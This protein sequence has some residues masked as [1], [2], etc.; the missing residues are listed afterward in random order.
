MTTLLTA[1]GS[2]DFLAA[3]PVVLG[4]HPQQSL[5]MLT[6]GATR[7][8]HARVDLPP[9]GDD[10]E[11]DEI[12]ASLLTPSQRHGVGQVVFVVYS[13]DGTTAARLAARL[14]PAFAAGGIAV[15]DVLRAHQ[16]RWSRVPLRAGGR[17][18]V[19]VRY[20]DDHHPFRAQAVLDGRVTRG[21]R[22]AVRATVAR[23]VELQRRWARLV[24]PPD[25]AQVTESVVEADRDEPAALCALVAGWVE[26]RTAPDDAGAARVLRSARRVEVRDALLEAV[27]STAA[28]DHVQVWSQLLRGAPVECVPDTAAVT[29]FCAW[30]AGDGALAWCALDRC[31][32]VDPEHRLG[33]CLAQCLTRAIPPTVWHEGG[34]S[35]PGRGA[36]PAER[37]A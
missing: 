25:G 37:S 16:G 5:V 18:T 28:P 19:P 6:F 2:E 12:V 33:T 3:V 34:P 23:D 20:D 15:I 24:D 10:G 30:L 4:F 22:E 14:V 7:T 31:F 13:A 35:D 21:S 8:F 26:S 9:P 17:E 36:G 29:A 32:E 1:R 27:T 11:D